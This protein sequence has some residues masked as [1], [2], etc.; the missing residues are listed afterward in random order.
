MRTI[1]DHRVG[2]SNGEADFNAKNCT[3]DKGQRNP[4]WTD[5]ID[6]ELCMPRTPTEVRPIPIYLDLRRN[7]EHSHAD[8]N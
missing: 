5:L 4:I 2:A 3:G 7:H 1:T 6:P 8:E